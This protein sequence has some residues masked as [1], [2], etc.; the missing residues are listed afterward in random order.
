MPGVSSRPP[1]GS[2]GISVP[3]KLDNMGQSALLSSV[4]PSLELLSLPHRSLALAERGSDLGLGS[5][6]TCL[7]APE[8]ART[9]LLMHPGHYSLES[10]LKTFRAEHRDSPLL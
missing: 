7:S 3:E 9:P 6:D 8:V 10:V 4:Q 5:P 1:A 2:A